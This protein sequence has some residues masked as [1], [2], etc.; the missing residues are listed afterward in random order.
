[1][2]KYELE[3]SFIDPSLWYSRTLSVNSK[4]WKEIRQII[5]KRD[6]YACSFCG[7]RLSKYMVVDHI[8]GDA[9]DNSFEN[10]RLN[11]KACDRIRHCGLAE[12]NTEICLGISK[13]SQT[14]IVKKTHQFYLKYGKNP[15][16]IKIDPNFYLVNSKTIS[17]FEIAELRMKNGVYKEKYKDFKGFFTENMDFS[18]LKWII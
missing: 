2:K 18:Y 12:I 5:L 10:L 16:P 17:C 15:N 8:S 11:C 4:K 14:E 7:I 1:M 3:L 6:N 9:S 13:L